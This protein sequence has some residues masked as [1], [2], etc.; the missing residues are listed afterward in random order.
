MVA[1]PDPDNSGAHSAVGLRNVRQRRDSNPGRS[2]L[3]VLG[4]KRRVIEAKSKE[5]AMNDAAA[6]TVPTTV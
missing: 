3:Y 5:P 4:T 6:T 1:P 2:G